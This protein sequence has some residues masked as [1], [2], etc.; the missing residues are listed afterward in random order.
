MA[1]LLAEVEVEAGGE[2][3][4]LRTA[5]RDQL[6]EVDRLSKYTV[7]HS[8]Q[9]PHHRRCQRSDHLL[10]CHFQLLHHWSRLHPQFLVQSQVLLFQQ[11]RDPN[12]GCTTVLLPFN[13]GLIVPERTTF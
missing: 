10:A 11:H 13:T 2:A 1:E 5:S 8:L 4:T 6:G 12:D 9:R 3:A 7:V